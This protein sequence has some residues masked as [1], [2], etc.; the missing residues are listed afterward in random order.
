MNKAKQG[1]LPCENISGRRRKARYEREK[2]RRRIYLL[3]LQ[4]L[5]V[6]KFEKVY[7][8]I[9]IG[10]VKLVGLQEKPDQKACYVSNLAEEE[11]MV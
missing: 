9:V 7:N 1:Q 10:R 8:E 3:T 5:P 4:S 2:R 11:I 6:E